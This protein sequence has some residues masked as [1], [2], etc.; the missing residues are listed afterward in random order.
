[1]A[2]HRAKSWR[3]IY[4]SAA[5]AAALIIA[6]ALYIVQPGEPDKVRSAAPT[7][8]ISVITTTL[9]PSTTVVPTTAVETTT[10]PPV[11]TT[12]TQAPTTRAPAPPT[13]VAPPSPVDNSYV[14]RVVSLTNQH[15]ATAGCNPLHI[16]N[17]LQNEA[18]MH[19]QVQSDEG[20]MHHSGGPWGENVARGYETPEDV[21]A[22]WMNST[23]HRNNILNCDYTE[24]GVGF[25]EDGYYW[26]QAFL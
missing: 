2:K 21:M 15:R 3:P 8:S 24:I 26:T 16:N 7:T 1:M 13:T 23:G 14:A 9:A 4:T 19:S 17:S 25:V 5:I 11:A 6:L 18:Q 22:A 20:Y 12:T 10:L